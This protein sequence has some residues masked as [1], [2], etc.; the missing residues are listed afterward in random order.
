M[1]RAVTIFFLFYSSICGA[2]LS[3]N[4]ILQIDSLKN[5]IDKAKHD[6]TIIKAWQS[7]DN[8]IYVSDPKLDLELNEKIEKLAAVNL[9]KSLT[10][11]EK[12]F[13][14]KSLASA[15]NNIGLIYQDQSKYENAL[16]YHK[17]SLKIREKTG[18]KKGKAASLGNIGYIY[19]EQG[20]YAT[21]IEYNGRC[22]KIFESIND[23]I[24]IAT[25]LNNFGLLYEDQDLHEKAI[26]YYTRSLKIQEKL[27][28]RQGIGMLLINFGNSYNE[29]AQEEKMK[30]DKS[31]SAKMFAKSRDFY[32]R[33][34]IIQEESG[35]ANG[36]ANVLNNI[37]SIHYINEEYADALD[38]FNQSL[39]LMKKID[40]RQGIAMILNNIGNIHYEQGHFAKSIEFNQEA[41][42][43]AQAIKV[44]IETRDASNS[45]YKSYKA[46][47]NFRSAL[48]MHELYISARDS[49]ES[50]ENQKEVIRH[51][52][53]YSY[54]KQTLADSIENA[55]ELKIKDAQAE[56][57]EVELENKRYQQYI[58]FGGLGVLIVFLGFVYNR[59]RITKKQKSII[60][61]QKKIVEEV[62]KEITDSIDYAERL[63]QCLMAEKKFLNQYLNQYFIYFN[64]KEKVSGDFYW[65]TTLING[66]FLLACA[67]STGHG[68]PG[69]MMSLM[70]MNSLKETVKDGITSPD[71][72]LNHSRNIIIETLSHDGSAEGGKDGMDCA[73]LCFDFKN[74]KL[75]FSLA[76]NP[77]WLIRKNELIE[78]KAD[79][80]PVGKHDKQNIP[81]SKNEIN[82]EKEDLIFIFTDGFADQFGGEKGKKF[83]YS[84]LQK[85]LLESA[86]NNTQT[87]HEKLGTAFSK[88]KGNLEQVDD[89][90]IIGIRI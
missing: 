15:Y 30:G 34:L 87:I 31:K 79:K 57:Q 5:L 78:Y 13:F 11:K 84:N 61:G 23:S 22:L 14:S 20:N 66:H 80:M 51:E 28:N 43:I 2:Q 27:G 53:K 7:W 73:L 21:A 64:P 86:S 36:I 59:F 38:Y 65:A 45:L 44:D 77:L 90:C 3:K 48:E 12:K 29:L 46:T 32:A 82:L 8:I 89:V 42:K 76:N 68:V 54:E 10:L 58:L 85:L 71:E 67:D 50:E 40:D 24:G 52:F 9:K 39:M 18:D 56:K 26:E 49:L 33:A 17:R 25:V 60:E 35:D 47:G 83:K 81:F 88:W 69:A 63:Q 1:K 4:E 62:H 6:S 41:L 19:Q 16:I 75:I 72:I 74:E 70:N 55:K 37:G